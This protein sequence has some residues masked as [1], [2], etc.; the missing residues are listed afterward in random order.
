M[1]KLVKKVDKNHI[2]QLVSGNL[3]VTSY[4]MNAKEKKCVQMNFCQSYLASYDL[5]ITIYIKFSHNLHGNQSPSAPKN[6]KP[7]AWR[8]VTCCALMLCRP[9]KC[10]I[11]RF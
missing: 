7:L 6:Q 11:Y 2:F 4:F 9:L 8:S 10:P 5:F 1:S 3:Q